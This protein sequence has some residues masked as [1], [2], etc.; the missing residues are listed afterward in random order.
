MGQGRATLKNSSKAAEGK[1]Q[2]VRIERAGGAEVGKL[3][4]REGSQR[5]RPTPSPGAQSFKEGAV[6]SL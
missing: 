4:K 2:T 3:G 1:L 5:R 6:Q